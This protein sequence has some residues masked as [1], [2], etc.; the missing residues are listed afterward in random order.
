MIAAEPAPVAEPGQKPPSVGALL[1]ALWRALRPWAAGLAWVVAACVALLIVG[2]KF[3]A[4]SNLLTVF[5]AYLPAWI[6]AL[7]ALGCA[8]FA[9]MFACWRAFLFAAFL[10]VAGVLWLSGAP[11]P[12]QGGAAAHAADKSDSITVLTY[13]RG[14]GATQLLTAFATSMAADMIAFQDAG[15]RLP[16]LAGLPEFVSHPH[17]AQVGEF[18]LLSRWPLLETTPLNLEWPET[19]GRPYTAGSRSVVD[20]NGRH[21]VVYNVHLPTPRDLLYWYGQRGTF[22]YGL[23]GLLPGTPLHARHQ[24][25]L[26]PWRSR[27]RLAGQL[28]SLVKAETAPVILMGDL[29]LPPVGEAYHKLRETLQDAHVMGG[30]GSGHTFPGNMK[31]WASIASPWVR[32]DYVFLSKDWRVLSCQV[33]PSGKSQHL[34]VAATIRLR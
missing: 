8:L 14:Q 23:L 22:L 28:A 11:L 12:F 24:Q 4:E 34:P 26:A 7:P 32:I 3:R 13:N 19:P 27:V 31:S 29:N 10:A 9:L 6:M 30:K 5:L 18:V 2:I 20:W 17:H 33:S 21:V 25:Y 15:R 16:Q 1:L